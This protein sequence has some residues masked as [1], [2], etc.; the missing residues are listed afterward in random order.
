M[1]NN[2]MKMARKLQRAI[3]QQFN[4]NL[5]INTNQWHHRDKDIFIN[6]YSVKQSVWDKEK[7]KN[8]T[9]ELF[10]TYSQIQLVL[11]LRD[12]WYELN[13]WDV[14]KDNPIWENI[15]ESYKTTK[16]PSNIDIDNSVKE[17]LLNI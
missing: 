11:F 2:F 1:A 12:L 17:N 6:V 16:K 8:I 9:T 3:K 4:I 5:L 14:P 15:K 10:L 13:G 7:N